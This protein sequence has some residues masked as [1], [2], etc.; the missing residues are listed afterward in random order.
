MTFLF[1]Q[2]VTIRLICT[3]SIRTRTSTQIVNTR[4][5]NANKWFLVN[6]SLNNTYYRY[7]HLKFNE[8]K[9]SETLI[10]WWKFK[11]SFTYTFRSLYN[12]FFSWQLMIINDLNRS[13][14]WPPSNPVF[15]DWLQFIDCFLIRRNTRS[16]VKKNCHIRFKLWRRRDEISLRM[17]YLY[18]TKVNKVF[19]KKDVLSCNSFTL[20]LP[21]R[22]NFLLTRSEQPS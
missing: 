15:P 22:F 8:L 6:G 5:L 19:C 7:F 13:L 9:V 21:L 2:A 18:L 14:V 11:I 1:P 16:G 17:C 3:T 12:S 10:F 20:Y 4:V